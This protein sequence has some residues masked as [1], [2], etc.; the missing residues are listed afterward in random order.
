MVR[1][2]TRFLTAASAKNQVAMLLMITQGLSSFAAERLSYKPPTTSI[3][4]RNLHIDAGL[5][6]GRH[7]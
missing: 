6:K 2:V 5:T 7:F 4:F 3:V 1:N